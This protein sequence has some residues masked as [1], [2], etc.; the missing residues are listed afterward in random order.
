MCVQGI[1]FVCGGG[2]VCLCVRLGVQYLS[3]FLGWGGKN[4]SHHNNHTS[5]SSP[6]T[7]TNTHTHEHTRTEVYKSVLAFA[8]Y[9]HHSF[10]R[11]HTQERGRV[12]QA[13]RETACMLRNCLSRNDTS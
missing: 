11:T 13:E 8:M 2:V 1:V 3:I 7:H 10:T 12:R 5:S 9:I 6:H 4:K